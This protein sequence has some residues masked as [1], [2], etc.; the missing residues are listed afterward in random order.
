VYSPHT[1]LDAAPGGIGDWLADIVTG[2]P[3]TATEDQK[4]QEKEDDTEGKKLAVVDDPFVDNKRPVYL[5]QHH[6]SHRDVIKDA[7]L[8]LYAILCPSLDP[9]II[10]LTNYSGARQVIH[11]VRFKHQTSLIFRALVWDVSS[12]SMS[13]NRFQQ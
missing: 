3:I 10:T 4:N 6:P 11:A 9:P 13:R 12:V 7:D 8:K 5:L 1:A 2:T